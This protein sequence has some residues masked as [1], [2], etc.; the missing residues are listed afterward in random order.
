MKLQVSTRFNSKEGHTNGGL[1]LPVK[2][3]NG[4]GGGVGGGAQAEVQA[5]AETTQA[6]IQAAVRMQAHIWSLEEPGQ[7]MEEIGVPDTGAQVCVGGGGRSPVCGARVCVCVGGGPSTAIVKE[8]G[9]G[10]WG[11]CPCSGVP[12]P[13]LVRSGEVGCLPLLWCV[14]V[15]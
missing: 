2:L 8:G 4:T 7:I 13:A 5:H 3:I 14:L 15:C 12:A 9:R 1:A 6:E 11:V 10:I